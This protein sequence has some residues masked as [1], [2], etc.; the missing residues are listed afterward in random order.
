MT[1]REITFRVWDKNKKEM[2]ELTGFAF[3][4]L[5]KDGSGI[6]DFIGLKGGFGERIKGKETD[7]ELMQY[8][9]LKDCK[10]N[11]I[12]EGDIVKGTCSTN[13][14]FVCAGL[15][16]LNKLGKELIGQIKYSQTFC[17]FYFTTDDITYLD[18][19]FGLENIEVLGNIY[20]NPEILTNSNSD[21]V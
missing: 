16:L 9:G 1:T 10:G 7:F 5:C 13:P 6:R 8:I 17:Q 20:S 11:K 15:K 2:H 14:E 4:D 3:P 21:S 19:E 18:L 12:F